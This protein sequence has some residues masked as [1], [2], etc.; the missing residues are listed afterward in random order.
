VNTVFAQL[1][2]DLADGGKIASG[3]RNAAILAGLPKTTSGLGTNMTNI[4]GTADPHV[5]DMA[6]AYATIAAQGKRATPYLITKVTS[7]DGKID[8][9][10]KKNVVSAFDSKVTA[11]VTDAM[12]RVVTEGTARK[13]AQG[14]GRPAAGKTGTTTDNLAAWFDGFTPQLSAAVGIYKNNGHTP[15]TIKK[16]RL[17]SSGG[18]PVDIWT[19]FMKGA[20]QGIKVIDFPGG[21]RQ[22][23]PAATSSADGCP[24]SHVNPRPESFEH[25]RSG[26]HDHVC[27]ADVCSA[28]TWSDEACSDQDSP[29][30]APSD[31]AVADRSSGADRPGQLQSPLACWAPC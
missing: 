30:P 5:I 29:E 3:V 23:A 13:N 26:S 2:I 22:L 12:T 1:N 19:A 17:I 11:D 21:R 25:V 18:I 6:N 16:D 14:L 10:V 28:D 24:Q 9:K 27:S 15:I 4:F 20:L 7:V 31:G 8:Y